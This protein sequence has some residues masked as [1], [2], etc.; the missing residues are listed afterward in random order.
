MNPKIQETLEWLRDQGL[1][2]LPVAPAQDPQRYPARDRT[3]GVKRDKSGE[4]LPAFTGKN[5]SYLGESGTPHLVRH[6]QYQKRLPTEVEV[7]QWFGNPANGIGTLGG[8]QNVVWIDVDLKQFESPEACDSRI[9]QWLAEYPLVQ[10]T[11]TE[12]THSGGWRFA[13]QAREQTFTNFSLDGVGGPHAGEALGQ[14][15][16]TVLAPT[17]GPSGNP[18][19]NLQRTQLVWVER[20]EAIGISPSS[21]RREQP[22]TVRPSPHV[23]ALPTS[24]GVL[25]LEDLAAAKARAVLYGESPFES[26]SHSLTF[27][28]REFY[29][30]ENWVTRNRVP[31]SGDAEELARA[32]GEALGIDGDRV[33]RIIQSIPDASACLPAVVFVGGESSAWNRIL[34]VSRLSE[35]SNSMMIVSDDKVREFVK[36][37]LNILCTRGYSHINNNQLEKYK[38]L[39]LQGRIYRIEAQGHRLTVQTKVRGKILEVQGAKIV[40]SHLWPVDLDR[41]R[42]EAQQIN[43]KASARKSPSWLSQKHTA[44]E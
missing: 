35:S 16:F 42:I 30:W 40:L 34:H 32:A 29:G 19:I 15:R 44:L 27:A 10:Q 1:P 21:R 11:F 5:P 7:Q 23:I 12:R 26:R 6:T 38:K 33:E 25:R 3:G 41:F 13:V 8:W 31:I 43:H 17:I 4:P 37:A 2:P 22:K 18:Y 24:P 9:N 20:L 39:S 36:D 14:G 28:L